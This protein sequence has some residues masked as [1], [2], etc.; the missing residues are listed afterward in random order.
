MSYL[1]DALKKAERERHRHQAATVESLS[2]TEVSDGGRSGGRVMRWVVTILVVCNAALLVY[3][4]RPVPGPVDMDSADERAATQTVASG[5]ADTAS[6]AAD[7]IEMPAPQPILRG[8]AAGDASGADAVGGDMGRSPQ[9]ASDSSSRRLSA[10]A[11]SGGGRV[12]YSQ[13]PLDDSAS[14]GNT[15][16]SNQSTRAPRRSAPPPSTNPSGVPEVSIN[17][18]LYSSVPGRSFILVN[19]QRYHEGERLSAGPAVESIDVTGATLNYRG[20]RFHVK[21]PG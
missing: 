15:A 8:R 20:E 12:T 17:G 1:V 16:A 19:G 11:D 10:G 4:F 21:G 3:L 2:A 5:S 6:G 18:H 9:Q 7:A 14:L 13:T